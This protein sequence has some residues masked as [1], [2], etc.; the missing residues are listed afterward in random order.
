MDDPQ[1]IGV[2]PAGSGEGPAPATDSQAT[3]GAE[4]ATGGH[5]PGAAEQPGPV[6]YDT[7]A[8]I[9]REHTQFKA[10]LERYS[11]YQPL[12]D[13]LGVLG[14][15]SDEAMEMLAEAA[16][17]RQRGGQPQQAQQFQPAQDPQEAEAQQ[18]TNWLLSNG[19]DLDQV[20]ESDALNTALYRSYQHGRQIEAKLAQW[21]ERFSGWE[22]HQK[23]EHA[24]QIDARLAADMQAIQQQYPVFSGKPALQKAIWAHLGHTF[25]ANIPPLEAVRAIAE[26]LQQLVRDETARY[27]ATKQGQPAAP[28]VTGGVAPPLADRPPN[29][30]GISDGKR[31]ELI[32]QAFA[33]ANLNS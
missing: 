8:P 29:L 12:V 20:R 14:L 10:Q 13:Q 2:A 18:Y 24:R 30:F 9:Q 26:E 7:F 4:G 28:A 5:T 25:R 21:D 32:Q 16:E 33:N 15:D 31:Q 19:H 22:E 3:T 11:P 6:P 23:R 17:I 1:A 27:A